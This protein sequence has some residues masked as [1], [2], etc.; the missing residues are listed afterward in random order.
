MTFVAPEIPWALLAPMVMVLGAG[1]LGVL[2]EAVLPRRLR[3]GSQI[4]LALLATAGAVVAVAYQWPT[5]SGGGGQSVL[6]GSL[7]IDAAG[8]TLQGLVA[9][10]GLLAL[11]VLADR[12]PAG[13]DAFAP[14]AAAVPGSEHEAAARRAGLAQTEVFPL[15]MF[16]LGGMMLFPVAADLLTLFVALEVVSLPLYLLAGM[17]RRRRLLSQEASLKYFL[18]SS[19]A[20]AFFLFGVA[21]LYGFAGSLRLSEITAAVATTT[22]LDPLLLAGAGLVL[23]G[24]LFKVG[25]VPFHSWTP[26]VYQ[27]SP[28]PITGF[29]AACTKAAAFGAI[30]RLVYVVLPP[31]AW[32]VLPALWGVAALTMVVGTLVAIVQTDVKRMLAYSSIAH[33]GFLLVGVVALRQSGITAVLFYLLAYGV[34]TVGAFAV[35]WLVREVQPGGA[36]TGEA[37]HLTQWT[38]LGRRHPVMAGAFTLFLLSFAGIPLTGGFIGKFAVFSAAIEGNLAWLAVV[39]V[40]ASIAAVFFYVRLVVLMY[41]TDPTGTPGESTSVVPG[42]GFAVVAIGL[43]A[44]ATVVLGVLPAPVLDAFAS[45]ASFIP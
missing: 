39:G 7:A 17:A 12:V 3:R 45:A 40:V 28:T 5:V 35:V 18:L 9:L 8:L 24:L 44:L 2:L 1:V 14:S 15:V 30:L 32:D 38:G 26:D 22:G 6:G 16:A 33:V 31:L 34:A 36:V 25:A 4:G 10:L 27:G 20:S 13:E 19:F 42:G 41:F 23:V 21:L 37:T 11:L 43:A 29:M